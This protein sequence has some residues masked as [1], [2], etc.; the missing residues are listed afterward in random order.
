MPSLNAVT[1]KV[2]F[3]GAGAG[4]RQL[5]HSALKD[6]VGAGHRHGDV[7]A[8][9]GEQRDAGL[10]T[11]GGRQD[12]RAGVD[13]EVGDLDGLVALAELQAT[14]LVDDVAG[15]VARLEALVGVDGG[16]ATGDREGTADGY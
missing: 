3:R 15:D 5:G 4:R 9:K 1:P 10:A 14:A 6:H 16:E 2:E 13:H 12:R 11:G 7:G 8:V